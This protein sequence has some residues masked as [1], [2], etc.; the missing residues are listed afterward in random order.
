MSDDFGKKATVAVS[1]GLTA[2]FASA[3]F[4]SIVD[5]AITSNASGREALWPSIKNGFKTLFQ[6]PGYFFRS[7]SFIWIAGVYS[8][9]YVVA[10]MTQVII[11]HQGRNPEL[12]KFAVTSVTNIAL[13][14][15]K[16]KAFA[17]MFKAE[18]SVASA[19]FPTTSL[20]LFAVRDSMTIF[21]SFVLPPRL[22]PV[23]SQ[24]L[25][26]P[27]AVARTGV[28]LF[29]PIAIQ[30][31]SVPM[32]LWALDLYNRPTVSTAERTSFVKREYVKTVLARW[33][34]IF[35]AYGIGGVINTEAQRALKSA[36]GVK[37]TKSQEKH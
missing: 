6:K 20:A 35:P 9:T 23:V 1:A 3:P 21:A 12:P 4:I 18:G 29:T 19:S 37:Q 27:D 25:G 28:Q 36:L 11:E 2:A 10:N 26:V 13:S 7:P 34:R 8:G 24:A 17:Q 33:G 14:M 16:D 22:T 5:K 30:V 31:F 15:L 32:H